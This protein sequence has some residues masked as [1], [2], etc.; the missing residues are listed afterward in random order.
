MSIASDNVYSDRVRPG[1]ARKK[2]ARRTSATPVVVSP[3]GNLQARL[4]RFA[5]VHRVW[6]LAVGH[7]VVFALAYWFAFMLRF[8][9]VVPANHVA[10]FWITLPAILAIQL[11]VFYIT[12]HFHGWWRYVTFSDLAALLR[13][14]AASLLA[15]VILNHYALEGF[16]PRA[17]VVMDCFVSGL[18]LGALRS[19]WRFFREQFWLRSGHQRVALMVGATHANG[20]LAHQIH[21][22][23]ELPYRIVGF[24]DNDP[25]RQGQ[26][27]GGIP[28]LGDIASAGLVAAGCKATELLVLADQL[29]G[30]EL[31]T[32]MDYCDQANLRLKVVPSVADQLNGNIPVR[33]VE[34]N[35]LLGREPVELDNRSITEEAAG[36]VILITG[37]GG[38]IGSEIC[39]QLLQ[40][41]PRQMI[42]VDNGE[43]ALFLITNELSRVA[44][45]TRL[46]PCVADV[47]DGD[48]MRQIFHEYRPDLVIHAAAHKHVGLMEGNVGQCVRNNVFGSKSVADLA[49]QFGASKFVLISTDKAVNPSS[50]MGASKQIAER[51]HSRH[52]PGI[53][54]GFRGRPFRK[55]PGF[56]WQRRADLQGTDPAWR[57]RDRHR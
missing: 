10:R 9:F 36:K 49:H 7:G 28:V 41:E 53:A 18:I 15:L 21:S 12:G 31:R 25:Q 23:D 22:H 57:S 26:R 56:Q 14:S 3:A 13:A 29:H 48:R 34:I 38:S 5:L 40:Y 8:D 20:I 55:C 17:V 35:D 6:L 16:V 54:H 1:L 42:L 19:S 45:T 44:E 30:S 33:D 52:G 2:T 4:V 11:Y 47:L 27:L 24:L 32:L 39:R 37:A 51:V 43:N 50:V 46:K